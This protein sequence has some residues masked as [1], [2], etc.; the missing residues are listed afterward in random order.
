MD[1]SVR[2]D[3]IDRDATVCV[4]AMLAGEAGQAVR[5]C[6]AVVPS[7]PRQALK[8]PC[9]LKAMTRL[10]DPALGLSAS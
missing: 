6:D 8:E 5:E 3:F 9:P 10:R 7:R 1:R 4:D 2:Q